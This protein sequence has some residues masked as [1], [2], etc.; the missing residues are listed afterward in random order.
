[1]SGVPPRIELG[2]YHEIH[3]KFFFGQAVSGT[4]KA[5]ARRPMNPKMVNGL[6][7]RSLQVLG[8]AAW[9]ARESEV[10]LE[11]SRLHGHACLAYARIAAAEPEAEVAVTLGPSELVVRRQGKVEPPDVTECI[12][13]WCAAA[14]AR[15]ASTMQGLAALP[16]AIFRKAPVRVDEYQYAWRRALMSSSTDPGSCAAAL[17][18]ARRLRGESRNTSPRAA[19]LND[20]CFDLLEALVAKDAPRFRAALVEALIAHA[21]LWSKQGDN[22]LNYRAWVAQRPLAMACLAQDGGLLVDVESD[23]LPRALVRRQLTPDPNL[24]LWPSESEIGAAETQP[25][26]KPSDREQ[27]P[28]PPAKAKAAALRSQARELERKIALLGGEAFGRTRLEP[29]GYRLVPLPRDPLASFDFVYEN[30]AGDVILVDT[31]A[32]DQKLEGF[33]TP[34]GGYIEQGTRTYVVAVTDRMKRRQ[35][36]AAAR[37][38]SALEAGRLEYFEVRSPI[39][40]SGELG[41]IEIRQFKL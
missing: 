40:P 10:L 33:E 39:L 7:E 19:T 12:R 24:E 41:N 38:A 4:R 32:A 16:D 6:T 18:E 20:R 26:P 13:G 3:R 34:Q 28:E 29:K 30:G 27:A 2:E 25:A 36:E 23:Y 17:A 21:K 37:I 11:T 14:I 22:H 15:D 31:L 8:G 1:M 35:A 9:W 5:L